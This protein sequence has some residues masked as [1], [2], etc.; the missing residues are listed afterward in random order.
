MANDRDNHED[1]V[2]RRH[3][4]ECMVWAGTCVLWTA[5]ISVPKLLSPLGRAE[6]APAIAQTKPTIAI[7]VK[8]TTSPYWQTVLAG[9][10]KAGQ[11]FG[12]P[13]PI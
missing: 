2:S 8:D 9:A 7:I 11:D 3:A 5:S 4:L 6:A 1:G 12:S 13:R 10:R